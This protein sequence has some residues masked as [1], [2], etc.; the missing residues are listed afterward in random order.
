MLSWVVVENLEGR[1]LPGLRMGT[2]FSRLALAKAKIIIK[3][4]FDMPSC[5]LMALWG[6]LAFHS[7]TAAKAVGKAEG[8]P[9]SCFDLSHGGT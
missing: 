1:P 6:T 7:S 2:G 5:S 8:L 3:V 9:A 4:A